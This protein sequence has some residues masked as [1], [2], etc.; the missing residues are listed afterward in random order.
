MFTLTA[1]DI[2]A[3][4][5]YLFI[6][7]NKEG[8]SSAHTSAELFDQKDKCRKITEW[9]ADELHYYNGDNPRRHLRQMARDNKKLRKDIEGEGK[10]KFVWWGIL[11]SAAIQILIRLWFDK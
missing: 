6:E 9:A 5:E 1:Q 8:W 3:A 7:L 10:F 2:N 4:A 11:I